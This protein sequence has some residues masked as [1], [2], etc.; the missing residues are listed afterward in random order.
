[1]THESCC[2]SVVQELAGGGAAADGGGDLFEALKR[3]PAFRYSEQAASQLVAQLLK[4]LVY[5]HEQVSCT[6]IQQLTCP[7]APVT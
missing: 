2:V 3:Q 6:A 5:L 7:T 1:M 4:A